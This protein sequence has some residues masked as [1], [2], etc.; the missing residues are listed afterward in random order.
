MALIVENGRLAAICPACDA[1]PPTTHLNGIIAPGF[2][3]LQVNGGAGVMVG[4][5]I[6]DADLA[7]ICAAHRAQ[8]VAGILPTLITDRPEV[9][10][11][12][13]RTVQRAAAAGLS[14]LLGLHLEGPHLD[15]RRHGAHDPALIRPMGDDDL[16]MLCAAARALPCLMVTLAP[17]AVRPDQMTAL[18]AAGAVISLG[19]SGC[20]LSEARAAF[21]AGAGC[22]THLF[23]AMSQ[24]GHR[25][26]GLV[27]ATLAGD[28]AAGL[29]ADGIHVDP[30]AL[31]VA[32]RARPR[33]LFL[34]SDCMAF[35]GTDLAEMNLGGRRIIRR[36]G[37]LT[38][39]DG[40]LAGADLTLARAV[41][42]IAAL[43]GGGLA[44]ALAMATAEPADVIGRPDLGRLVPGMRAEFTVIDPERCEAQLLM[45]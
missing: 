2:L 4:A 41:G 23:N 7:T 6:D 1:G 35:A 22:V 37:R 8:G 11:H 20:T 38:L 21:D 12:V 19:H 31:S 17:E 14:G 43:P 33:G 27:G 13:I 26:P 16:A 30:A 18:R 40:T 39:D 36:D 42:M 24:M 44:R 45:P 5:T 34:V 28:V 32:L 25:Q 9:T 10:R 3:D 29:I 15:P